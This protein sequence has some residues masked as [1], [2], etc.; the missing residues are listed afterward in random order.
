MSGQRPTGDMQDQVPP[1]SCICG[2]T[3]RCDGFLKDIPD[4]GDMA[5]G[6]SADAEARRRERGRQRRQRFE[7]EGARDV[8]TTPVSPLPWWQTAMSDG[9]PPRPV[10][11]AAGSSGRGR[12]DQFQVVLSCLPAPGVVTDAGR[13]V[14]PLGRPGRRAPSRGPRADR[15]HTTGLDAAPER[16]G[17]ST[18]GRPRLRPRPRCT[19]HGAERRPRCLQPTPVRPGPEPYR[20]LS[21]SAVS[22][23]SRVQLWSV[24]PA[25]QA[26]DL[27]RRPQPPVVL[28]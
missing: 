24:R 23:P 19:R 16:A 20:R 4:A 18:G 25:R 12:G 22:A 3:T 6:G 28:Q 13:S 7:H 11:G 9:Q 27:E 15:T 14:R 8:P 10:P 5:S 1:T 21:P 2:A 17:P 26:L